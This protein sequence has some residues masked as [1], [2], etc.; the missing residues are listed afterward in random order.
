MWPKTSEGVEQEG[1]QDLQG[2]VTQRLSLE[3]V[4]DVAHISV[5]ANLLGSA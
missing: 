2:R 1:G 4:V 3:L 5:V